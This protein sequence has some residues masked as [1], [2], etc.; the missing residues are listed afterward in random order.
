MIFK[1]DL[2]K[3]GFPLLI[4]IIFPFAHLMRINLFNNTFQR[5]CI[6]KEKPSGSFALN[7]PLLVSCPG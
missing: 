2:T 3:P 1:T 5:S 4:S 7:P 6:A